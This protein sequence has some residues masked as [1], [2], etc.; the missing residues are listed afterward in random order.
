MPKRIV[1]GAVLFCIAAAGL[2]AYSYFVEP[3]ELE[4]RS[5]ELAIFGL[6]PGLDGLK[7]VLISDVHG[8]SNDVTEA[9][10]TEVTA[11]ANEQDPDLIVLLGDFVS[12]DKSAGDRRLK[13]PM[14]VVADNMAGLRAKLGVFAVLGNHDGEYG[15]ELVSAELT[16]V[17]IRVLQNEVAVIE[18]NGRPL[19]ILGFKDHLNLNRRWRRTSEDAI[20]LLEST[21]DG[22]LIAL[23]HS[24]DIM[25]V[26]TGEKLISPKLRLVL[27]GHTHGGQ[28]W[29]P[30]LGRAIIPS[31][32]GQKFAYGHVRENGIDLFV[33]SGIG[34]SILP[35]RF[36]VPPEIVVL[37]LRSS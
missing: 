31:S 25:E 7:I 6:D 13:M 16:R 33:T 35:I 23:E 29:L 30:I 12:R 10:L 14:P 15:D 8:G 24:P 3:R 20:K 4:V 11:L 27:A 17:G 5:T 9:K 2:L 34:T 18:R 32:F 19:R 22:D 26:I 21:G 28:V 37:T 36:L 1:A